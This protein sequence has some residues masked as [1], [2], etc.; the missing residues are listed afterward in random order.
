MGQVHQ[1][2]PIVL[3]HG[4]FGFGE[5]SLGKLKVSYFNRIDRALKERGTPLIVTRVHP[6]GSIELRARQL[7]AAILKQLRIL[8]R[9]TEQ[10]EPR[11]DDEST[12][13]CAGKIVIFAH[14]MGGLDARY[15]ISKLGMADRVAALVTLS[16]PH[17]GSPYA[18]WCMI[19]LGKRL[20]GLQL[21]RLLGIDVRAVADL[22]T[23]AC[24]KCN[25]KIKNHP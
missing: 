5:V 16:T 1:P 19:N 18:D 21:M 12:D 8:S 20:K 11:A 14:S 10:R 6:T 22:T 7:K 24:R 4:L 3:S 17:R 23:D 13:N 2:T 25:R 15:M 9:S